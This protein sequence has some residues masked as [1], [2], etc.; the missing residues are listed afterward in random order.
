MAAQWLVDLYREVSN[1]T[2]AFLSGVDVRT[3][4]G[5]TGLELKPACW[6]EC[7]EY[8]NLCSLSSTDVFLNFHLTICA[9]CQEQM[10]CRRVAGKG[11]ELSN[12]KTSKKHPPGIDKVNHNLNFTASPHQENT[13]PIHSWCKRWQRSLLQ[14][15]KSLHTHVCYANAVVG[16]VQSGNAKY[17]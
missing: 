6:D 5:Q 1:L 13:Q 15:E 4:A 12:N 14:R 7:D 8:V 11:T 3:H 2:A 10:N 17:K 16:E 9:C